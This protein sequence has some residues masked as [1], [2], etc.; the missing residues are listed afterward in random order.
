MT[1]VNLYGNQDNDSIRW[2]DRLFSRPFTVAKGK[3]VPDSQYPYKLYIETNSG[4]DT[5][6]SPLALTILSFMVDKETSLVYRHRH[7]LHLGWWKWRGCPDLQQVVGN[8]SI[9]GSGSTSDTAADSVVLASTA[10]DINVTF[11]EGADSLH[12]SK[13]ATNAT[14]AAGGGGDSLFASLTLASSSIEAGLGDDSI[15]L[16]V[17][18][19]STIYAG[20][21][22]DSITI[23]KGVSSRFTP[24]RET[25]HHCYR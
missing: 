6:M 17:L 13:G 16:S 24:T 23:A 20:S 19:G 15:S 12:L 10:T 25:I 1:S 8:T 4:N 18:S 3:I 11:A 22:A 21:G 2:T 14:I 5:L 9:Q 7:Q